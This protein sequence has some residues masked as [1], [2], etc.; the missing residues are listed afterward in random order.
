MARLIPAISQWKRLPLAALLTLCVLSSEA[1]VGQAR[2]QVDGQPLISRS[3]VLRG[4]FPQWANRIN[5]DGPL[6]PTEAMTP[7]TLVLS[8]SPQR[9]VEFEKFLAEQQDATSPNYHRWLTPDQVGERFGV[10][11]P[12]IERL[13]Q[14]LQSNH[15]HVD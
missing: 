7:L 11:K 2:S 1:I 12:D 10:P 8:R 15:L 14:W 5:D 6:A 9:E 13:T 3:Q 4:H